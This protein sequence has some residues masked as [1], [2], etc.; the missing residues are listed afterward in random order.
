MTPI[1][2]RMAMAY[3]RSRG[4]PVNRTTWYRWLQRGAVQAKRPRGRGFWWTTYDWIDEAIMWHRIPLK[5]GRPKECAH[6]HY[7]ER[8]R[9]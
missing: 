3:V 5:T 1:P 9:R 8:G 7:V 4:I 6:A 2:S